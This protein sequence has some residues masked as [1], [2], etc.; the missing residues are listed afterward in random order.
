VNTSRISSIKQ[1]NK[2][3]TSSVK[4]MNKSRTSSIK[5]MNKSRTSS[6][7]QVNNN[8]GLRR[9]H[10]FIPPVRNK[11]WREKCQSILEFLTP[12]NVCLDRINEKAPATRKRYVIILFP[13]FV[14][15]TYHIISLTDVHRFRFTVIWSSTN[16]ENNLMYRQG[17]VPIEEYDVI[18]CCFLK[19]CKL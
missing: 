9:L 11:E 4:Q 5:Q 2:S 13:Y 12:Q 19:G 6:I 14:N 8:A 3:G 10:Q 15:L 1:V 18:R 16:Y 7:K 17:N